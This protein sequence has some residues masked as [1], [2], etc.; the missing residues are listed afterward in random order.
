MYR[1]TAVLF[2]FLAAV[3]LVSATSQADWPSWRGPQ[4]TGLALDAE[5]PT[6]WSE[7]QNVAWKVELPGPGHATPVIWGSASVSYNPP[8]R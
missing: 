1:P 4:E 2:V 7:K 5:P 8:Q 6:E 3:F